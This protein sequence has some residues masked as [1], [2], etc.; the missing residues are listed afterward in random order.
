[1]TDGLRYPKGDADAPTAWDRVDTVPDESGDAVTGTDQADPVP[2]DELSTDG[3]IE[4]HEV[5]RQ[6]VRLDMPDEE[7]VPALDEDG[8]PLTRENEMVEPAD[9]ED[10]EYRATDDRDATDGDPVPLV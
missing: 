7:V 8:R 6:G 2:A 4:D 10:M 9:S 1:M 5:I 3:D